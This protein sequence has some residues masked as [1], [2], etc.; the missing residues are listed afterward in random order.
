MGLTDK[1]M[2]V[3]NAANDRERLKQFSES[4][5]ISKLISEPK[6]TTRAVGLIMPD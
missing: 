2:N 4:E 6:F 3:K 5:F 1:E